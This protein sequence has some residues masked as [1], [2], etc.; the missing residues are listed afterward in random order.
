MGPTSA[1]EG[2]DK[3]L[4]PS[5]KQVVKGAKQAKKGFPLS[6][7]TFSRKLFSM[8]YFYRPRG[9]EILPVRLPSCMVGIVYDCH[10]V[11]PAPNGGD[12]SVNIF[13]LF[14]CEEKIFFYTIVSEIICNFAKE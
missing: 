4:Q 12:K 2:P 5:P 8:N 14:C 11:G 1:I 13:L 10:H 7:S 9:K 6:I 3:Y